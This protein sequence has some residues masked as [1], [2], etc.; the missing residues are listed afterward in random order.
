MEGK[1]LVQI[2]KLKKNYPIF[3]GLIQKVIGNVHAVAGVDLIIYE[4]ETMGLVGESGCGKTT[5]GKLVLRLEEPTDGQIYFNGDNILNMD[6]REMRSIRR[7]MQII[8]QDP[9]SSLNFRRNVRQILEEP[10]IVHKTSN[11]K[12]E[13]R[14]RIKNLLREVGLRPEHIEY[15]PHQF[16]GG[17]AQRIA[18]ARA[19]ALNPKFIVC[20]EP[21]SALDVS[22]QAQ[23]INLLEE[24]QE[25]YQLTYLFISHDLSVVAHICNKISVMYLGRIVEMSST[26]NICQKPM[27]PYTKALIAASP[28]PNPFH[29]KKEKIILKGDVPSPIDPPSGCHFHTRCPYAFNRCD[30]EI[31][32]LL[33]I[34]PG[35]WVRCFLFK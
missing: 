11:L 19:I 1:T 29:Q 31:P 15:Y 21:V 35:H 30:K 20:D 16:S 4:G 26:K 14:E 7:N 28:I 8:F 6:N 23:A 5:L 3:S 34:A 12:L 13:R 22:V 25:K 10:F 17:Q 9:F 27:H 18:I 33:E 32:D 2:K 24:L